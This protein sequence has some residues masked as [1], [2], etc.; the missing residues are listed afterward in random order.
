M[1]EG[2]TDPPPQPIVPYECSD[3]EERPQ[4]EEAAP[5]PAP[6]EPEQE[7]TLPPDYDDRDEAEFSEESGGSG[8][9]GDV[10]KHAVPEGRGVASGSFLSPLADDWYYLNISKSTAALTT[11]KLGRERAPSVLPITY[12]VDSFCVQSLCRKLRGNWAYKFL[13]DK[14][15]E[16]ICPQGIDLAY[17]VDGQPLTPRR[18]VI[19]DINTRWLTVSCQVLRSMLAVGYAVVVYGPNPDVDG[20]NG[21]VPG[22]S[23]MRASVLE[24]D[25]YI[26]EWTTDQNGQRRYI[27][28]PVGPLAAANPVDDS[29]RARFAIADVFFWYEPTHNGMPQSKAFAA[30]E[31]LI[32][33]NQ[34]FMEY[35]VAAHGRN[36]QPLVVQSRVVSP[37]RRRG[38]RDPADVPCPRSQSE[39]HHDHG[40]GGTLLSDYAGRLAA[41]KQL[42]IEHFRLGANLNEDARI[43]QDMVRRSHRW[44]SADAKIST[45]EYG[46]SETGCVY[47]LTPD[48]MWQRIL[49]PLPTNAEIAKVNPPDLPAE[50]STTLNKAI[51]IVCAIFGV[52]AEIVLG[53]LG[54]GAHVAT[55][56]LAQEQLRSAVLSW[57]RL[58][59]T[60]LTRMYWRVYGDLHLLFL[61]DAAGREGL[62]LTDEDARAAVLEKQIEFS[63]RSNALDD[64]SA[65]KLFNDGVLTGEGYTKFVMKEYGLP[66]ADVVV[67]VPED[68]EQYAAALA[69]AMPIAA[70]VETPGATERKRKGK[71]KTSE[72]KQKKKKKKRRTER[73]ASAPPKKTKEKDKKEKKDED[74]GSESIGDADA[75]E[76]GAAGSAHKPRKRPKT[77][78]PTRL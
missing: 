21:S 76:V 78:K 61:A 12:H 54:G 34:L 6:S 29:G 66:R 48:Q 5:S 17:Y 4:Q 36:N 42:G 44:A 73:S 62:K 9:G 72:S 45:F 3:D 2:A 24:P 37:A 70:G 41:E 38:L 43:R 63:F 51:S 1:E 56:T 20:A 13:S 65:R 39:S 19:E 28:R 57:R 64:E 26:L 10:A 16:S 53:A 75:G 25:E 50:Y 58:L 7:T 40:A 27:P 46:D 23:V 33:I 47:E 35:R 71:D 67:P 68:S 22:A 74:S 31:M 15:W 30:F 59:C 49:M 77:K 11:A 52:P 18:S 14:L 69:Q 60:V 55:A 32:M 8:G